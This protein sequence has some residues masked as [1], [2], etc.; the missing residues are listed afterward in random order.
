MPGAATL[1]AWDRQAP[2]WAVGVTID[3]NRAASRHRQW[4]D[5]GIESRAPG[6]RTADA[7]NGDGAGEGCFIHLLTDP[8]RLGWEL[9][10]GAVHAEFS[11]GHGGDSLFSDAIHDSTAGPPI[12]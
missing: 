2:P 3:V 7:L 6:V 10:L 1:R 4:P 8:K 9:A 5:L 12:G 11:D